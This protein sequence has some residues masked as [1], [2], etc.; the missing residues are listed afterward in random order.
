LEKQTEHTSPDRPLKTEPARSLKDQLLSMPRGRPVPVDMR[1][2]PEW[3]QDKLFV[4]PPSGGA[5]AAWEQSGVEYGRK[6]KVKIKV[7]PTRKAELIQ[8]TL[9]NEQGD[10]IFAQKDIGDI[11]KFDA[12]VVNHLFAAARK[13][14]GQDV[15]ETD[16]E[17]DTEGNYGRSGGR[18]SGWPWARSRTSSNACRWSCSPDSTSSPTVRARSRRSTPTTAESP[19]GG[20]MTGC[21]TWR[22][23]RSPE[24]PQPART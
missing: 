15:E 19:A 14:A 4:K 17:E 2:F 16:D 8:L 1:K 5:I 18:S 11:A 12:A 21:W 24:T 7:S 6:G 13:V 22:S 23:G 20:K 10:L 9:C 3:P